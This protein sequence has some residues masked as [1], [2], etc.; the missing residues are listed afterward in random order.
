[1]LVSTNP[2]VIVVHIL[3]LVCLVFAAS[4]VRVGPGRGE[5]TRRTWH[6]GWLGLA[7]V[8]FV[9]VLADFGALK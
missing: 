2:I 7:L 6:P 8:V 9:T 1:M 5:R 3:A 4:G